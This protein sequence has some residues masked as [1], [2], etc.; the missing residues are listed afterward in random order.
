MIAHDKEVFD[1][2]CSPL[3]SDSFAS[4]GADGSVR[5]FDIRTLD[6]STIIWETPDNKPLL[7][8]HWNRGDHNYIGC[9]C[10]DSE[11]ATILDIRMP[12]LPVGE[13]R[14]DGIISCMNWAPH[15]PAIM[16]TAEIPGKLHLWDL[17]ISTAESQWEFIL[18]DEQ[19]EG[20]II[21]Q[22]VWSEC[23]PDWYALGLEKCI[24]INHI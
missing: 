1:V 19:E 16:M 11:K 4:C 22:I 2:Q 18:T 5:L 17:N 3:H 8:I 21:Q 7:R 23:S 24:Y 20:S 13:L 9:L 12:S 15:N 6:H 14:G 10:L